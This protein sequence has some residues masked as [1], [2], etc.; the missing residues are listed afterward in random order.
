MS[1]VE[2]FLTK[3][4]WSGAE[5]APLAGDASA[6]SYQRL[7]RGSERAV[8]MV[9][10]EGNV[11][12]FLAVARHLAAQGLSAPVI[13]ADDADCGIVLMEDFGDRL[14]AR[15]ASDDPSA[16]TDLY[17]AAT[18]V[19]V[20]L[21]G[22]PSPEGLHSYGPQE[23]AVMIGPAAEFY[24]RAAGEPVTHEGWLQL[25]AALE[26][27]LFQTDMQPQ[28]MIH[29]DY[30]AENLIWL[31]ERAGTARVGLLDFQDALLGH[32]A[33]DLASLLGDVRRDVG[34]DA[35]EAAVRCYVDSTGCDEGRF[36]AAL[37][38]QGAQRNLRI[39]GVFTRLCTVLSKPGYLDL[40]PRAWR[41]LMRD[42][43]HPDLA[44][45]K[46]AVLDALPEPTV[47][48]LDRIRRVAT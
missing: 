9:D 25:T 26:E 24:A 21:H 46:D 43:T 18:E 7:T 33:Y 16:E 2:D 15:L 37:A 11:E 6:R 23:M 36:R 32:P 1:A 17:V 39:L 35:Q 29:R 4:G 31:P 5:A 30:H 12:A 28:V 20:K 27:A 48:R 34:P 42:L 8:L 10:P 40:M 45:L 47:E 44:T 22:A 3:A 41:N 14:I 13:F 19:L 38:A